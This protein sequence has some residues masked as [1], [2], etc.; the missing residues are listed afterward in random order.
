MLKI[1]HSDF[2][3]AHAADFSTTMTAGLLIFPILF[4]RCPKGVR[5]ISSADGNRG[6]CS[7]LFITKPGRMAM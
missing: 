2:P 3:F 5:R 1:N 6:G 4:T 7:T